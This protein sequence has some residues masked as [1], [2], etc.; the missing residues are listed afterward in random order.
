MASILSSTTYWFIATPTTSNNTPAS[1]TRILSSL[2]STPFGFVIPQNLKF[3]T[4]D[5]LIKLTDDLSKFDSNIESTLRR[6]ERSLLD[7][8]L[9]ITFTVS[10]GRCEL[11][12]SSY[13]EN[14]SW[15]DAK[16]PRTRPLSELVQQITTAVTRLDE[17]VK[18][19]TATLTD[20]KQQHSALN[21]PQQQSL[22]TR[23]LVEVLTPANVDL[24]LFVYTEHLTTVVVVVGR[25]NQQEFMQTYGT[26]SEWVVPESAVTL[27]GTDKEGNLLFRVVVFKKDQET[28]K[29]AA[30]QARYVVRDFIYEAGKYQELVDIRVAVSNE[31]KK[32]ET[33][34][35]RV[36]N[37]AYSDCL[38]CLMHLNGI[39]VFVEAVLR[40]GLPVGFEGFVVKVGGKVGRVREALMKWAADVNTGGAA[41][42]T[43]NV[44]GEEEGE[45]FFPYVYFPF[46][47]NLGGK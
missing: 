24:T 1:L 47:L 10:T 13:L 6:I 2:A 23:D 20:L 35:R 28:F 38:V 22:V 34:T 29:A 36:L 15:D 45:A 31:L 7:I 33:V 21:K 17:E 37:A 11:P 42:S 41:G 44:G 46:V 5:Q 25:Q 30:R 4:F 3:S 32:T 9:A 8:D 14:F 39:R 18:Q 27:P 40:W 26:L 43:E 16:F 12:A 19:R